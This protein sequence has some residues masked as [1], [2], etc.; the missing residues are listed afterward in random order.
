[1]LNVEKILYILKLKWNFQVSGSQTVVRLPPVVRELPLVV[2]EQG[3][4]KTKHVTG[5]LTC[6]IPS[7]SGGPR[8]TS[9]LSLASSWRQAHTHVLIT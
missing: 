1:M 9:T 8:S 6:A 7:V 3:G 4:K 2:C 5:T